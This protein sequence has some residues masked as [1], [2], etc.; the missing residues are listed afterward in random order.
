MPEFFSCCCRA[1]TCNQSARFLFVLHDALYPHPYTY[2]SGLPRDIIPACDC[3]I[4]LHQ[5]P[6]TFLHS[7]GVL[8]RT[9]TTTRTK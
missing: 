4:L 9:S 2:T 1:V 3:S 8:Q 7:L 6:T 5:K